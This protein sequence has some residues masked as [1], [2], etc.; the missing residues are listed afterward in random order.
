MGGPLL[1][2]RW[3]VSSSSQGMLRIDLTEYVSIGSCGQKVLEGV[4]TCSL[5]SYVEGFGFVR[6]TSA[7]FH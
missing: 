7:G 4:L 1:S 5:N 6:N 2:A 3:L